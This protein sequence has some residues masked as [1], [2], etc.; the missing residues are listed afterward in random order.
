M[1]CWLNTARALDRAARKRSLLATG[2]RLEYDRLILGDRLAQRSCPPSTGSA[3][4]GSFTLRLAE[5]AIAMRAFVQHHAARRDRRRRRP[6]RPGVGLRAV[7]ARA[8]R[9]RAGTGDRLM[10]RQLDAP[11]PECSS[12]TSRGS[13]SR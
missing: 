4:P 3:A 9:H 6:A 11:A 1:T 8:S 12:A 2:E 7:Q 10:R 13:G 5:D